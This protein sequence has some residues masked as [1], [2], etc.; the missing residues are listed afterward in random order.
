MRT[1]T[2]RNE[3]HDEI[4]ELTPELRRVLSARVH[5]P[6]LVDDL[7]QEALA[8]V[9]AARPRLGDRALAPY[10]VVVARNLVASLRRQELRDKRHAHRLIDLGSPEDPEESSLR[11]EDERAVA[12]ALERLSRGERDMVISH[13]VMEVDTKTIATEHDSSPGAVA[14]RLARLRARL[15]VDYLIA[16][17]RD[18]PPT[19]YCRPV[20]IAMSAGETRSQTR[21]GAGEHIMTCG[22][23]A[24]LSEPVLS[25]RRPAAVFIPAAVVGRFAGAL[26]RFFRNPAGKAT[27]GAAAAGGVV[28]AALAVTQDRP[29]A[30]GPERGPVM[31]GAQRVLPLDSD[32]E[33][34]RY[35]GRR[36]IATKALV[37]SVPVDEGFWIGSARDNR[38]FVSLTGRAESRTRIR[39][40]DAVSFSG[41]MVDHRRSF[42][43][44]I[45]VDASEGAGQLTLQRA[46]V[47]VPFEDLEVE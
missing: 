44:R 6:Q 41:S 37:E 24:E 8:R 28:I 31:A 3:G 7:V 47:V 12:S 34:V 17:R 19:A 25:R 33:V 21:L 36:V 46:H 40:G 18:D 22:F 39:P 23:C 38:I 4:V 32:G 11:R 30:P 35:V 26:G 14:T 27:I 13:E 15:R 2:D 10:A 20:L 5:D 29:P 9:L 43:R 16:L 42:A 1:E 45:G